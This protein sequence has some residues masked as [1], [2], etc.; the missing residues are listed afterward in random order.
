MLLNKIKRLL[1]PTKINK[2]AIVYFAYINPLKD[3]QKFISNQLSDLIKTNILSTADLHIIVSNPFKAPNVLNFFKK[4]KHPY[5]NIEL[6]E[7]NKFEY[8]GINYVWNLAREHNYEYVIYFHTKG[9]SHEDDKRSNKKEML[10]HHTFSQWQSLTKLFE[11]NSDINKIGLFP[12][13][14]LNQKGDIIRGGWIWY[15]FWW[16]RSSYIQTL[17]KPNPA[18]ITRYYYESWLSESNNPRNNKLQ[19]NFSI[20]SMD[21]KLY[22]GKETLENMEELIKRTKN[23]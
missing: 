10:T 9:I 16:A 20:Y 17:E 12:G 4:L 1:N 19:D 14:E 23:K 18:P 7:E 8:W 3:W 5:K 11:E 13:Y 22:T 21:K 6:Y 15:N 2:I